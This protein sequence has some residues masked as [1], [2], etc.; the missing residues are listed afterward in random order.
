M[1]HWRNGSNDGV[2]THRHAHV[3]F[4]ASSPYVVACGGTHVD[5][6]NSAISQE[7]VWNDGA[8]GGVSDWFGLPMYQANASIPPLASSGH[9][10]GRGGESELS[11]FMVQ[12][13]GVGIM[14]T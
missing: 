9:R 6:M 4:P 7:V 5:V 3:D 10:V 13:Q 1:H 14:E 8:G 11:G 2:N 12:R